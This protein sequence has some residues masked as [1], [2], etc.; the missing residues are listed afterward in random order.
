MTALGLQR[1]YYAAV[2]A[3]IETHGDA[4][5]SS[6][7]ATTI[8]TIMGEWS[9][10]L[11]ALE[12]GAYDALADRVDWAA[13]KRLF[14]ALKRRRPDV[15]FAQLEQLE[16]DYH[17]IAN[18]RL[19]GSLTC[20]Q[21]AAR[22]LDEQMTWQS[23]CTIRRPTLVQPCVAN[24]SGSACRRSP[25]LCRLDPSDRDG[26]RAPRSRAPRPLRVR[27]DRRIHTVDECAVNH[28]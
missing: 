17:D 16:L 1:R 26:S 2:K 20:P 25:V 15:T 24:S 12:R 18:G 7:P 10:V 22:T 23:P 11:D 5:A 8:D 6:L 13:K 14:D 4:L 3:F 28:G 9:R 27:A 19:Y 21:P